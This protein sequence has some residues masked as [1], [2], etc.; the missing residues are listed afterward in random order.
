MHGKKNHSNFELITN[1]R[2]HYG[3]FGEFLE[4]LSLRTLFFLFFRLF[5]API[6]LQFSSHVVYYL[7][8]FSSHRIISLCNF[9]LAAKDLSCTLKFEFL[10][11]TLISC[12]TIKRFL[13]LLLRVRC[14]PPHRKFI[15]KLFQCRRE[16]D[17]DDRA[18][19]KRRIKKERKKVSFNAA[20]VV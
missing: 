10:W 2:S 7:V 15:V 13:E 1:S 12:K 3:A 18:V 19:S 9:F 14:R 16:R 5:Q 17:V 6:I 8:T 20:A 11:T 4:F